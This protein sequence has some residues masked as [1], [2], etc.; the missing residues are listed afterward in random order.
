MSVCFS[1]LS[2]CLLAKDRGVAAIFY[3][4][5]SHACNTTRLNLAH[6]VDYMS[7]ISQ[8]EVFAV[9]CWLAGKCFLFDSCTPKPCIS[10]HMKPTACRVC[11]TVIIE[12]Q[13]LCFIA[14]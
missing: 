1:V 5:V 8:T 12:T 4:P 13:R 7:P 3:I 9:E 6:E 10:M 2:V 14:M 11:F